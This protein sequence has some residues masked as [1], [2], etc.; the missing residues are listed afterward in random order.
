MTPVAEYTGWHFEPDETEAVANATA[1]VARAPGMGVN[2]AVKDRWNAVV[3][4]DRQIDRK[5]A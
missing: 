3:G 4:N 1:S 5:G 2:L